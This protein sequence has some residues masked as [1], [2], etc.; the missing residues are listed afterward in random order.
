MFSTFIGRIFWFALVLAAFLPVSSRA[1]S[2]GW[3]H[4]SGNQILDANNQPVRIAGVNWYGFE[5]QH[6]VVQGLWAQ[7]YRVVLNAIKN[8]GYNTIRLPFSNQMVEEGDSFVPDNIQFS[9]NGAPINTDLMGLTSLQVMDKVI[10]YAGQIGLKIILDNHRSTAG[11]GGTEKYSYLWYDNNYPE[12]IWIE[13]WKKLVRRY[14]HD[15]TVVGVDLRNEPH[16]PEGSTTAGVCWGCGGSN[17]WQ[18]GAQRGGNAVLRINSDLLI[19]VE[20]T[21]C[22]RDECTWWGGNLAGVQDHPVVLDVPNRLVYSAHEYGPTLSQQPWFDSNTTVESLGSRFSHFWGYISEQERAPVWVGEFGTSNKNIDIDN[23]VAGSQGQWFQTMIGYLRTHREIGW[24]YWAINGEDDYGLL[25]KTYQP[26]F[27]NALKQRALAGIQSSIGGVSLRFVPVT[28]CRIADT[29]EAAG[30]F[31]APWIAG[32]STRDFIVPES[33][34]NIPAN[35]QAYALNV[36]AVPEKTLGWLTIWPKGQA[37]PFVS[38]LNSADGRVKANAAI[39]PA[40]ERG[41]VSVFA[42][43]NTN[44]ILDISGYFVRASE[45][46]GLTFYPVA[47]CRIADT[48]SPGGPLGAPFLTAGQSRSFPVLSSNCA[49]PTDSKAYSLNFTVVPHRPLAYL[50]TWP[51]GQA[52]PLVSTLNAS[53]GATTANGAIVPASSNGDISV[54]A[55]DDTEVII[56]V[57]GYFASQSA[58]GLSLY[59]TQPCRV[60]DTRDDQRSLGMRGTLG[61]RFSG[62]WCDVAHDASAYVTNA[63]VVPQAVQGGPASLSYLTLYPE[64]QQQPLVSTLNAVDGQVTSNLAIVPAGN[65]GLIDVFATDWTH[66]ILDISGYFAP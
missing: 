31:G 21:D 49:L 50:T 30:P 18:L 22:Y 65:G 14:L 15:P 23:V 25:L 43:D 47:P 3:W 52:Q 33:G 6:Q 2:A 63:T 57:N 44:V 60:K 46:P 10:G 58:G 35:A 36:T 41:G 56:D 12:G 24:T 62:G 19:F 38:T 29:R 9:V 40:G 28:P 32:Q 39:V 4:T 51:T 11:D 17:D 5:N 42:T 34:C 7:D 64:G 13:D 27:S 1:A 45:N 59:N 55:S 26:I 20:G 53:T 16:N 8:N 61:I 37:R 48:R 54:F 66:F